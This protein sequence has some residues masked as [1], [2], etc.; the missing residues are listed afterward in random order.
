[1]GSLTFA[2]SLSFLSQKALD[3]R[4]KQ[5]IA[6]D[7]SDLPVVTSYITQVMNASSAVKLHNVS[8]WFNQ[9][10]VITLDSST[11]TAMA[12]LPMVQNVKL[13][14]RYPNGVYKTQPTSAPNKFASVEPLQAKD[15][16]QLITD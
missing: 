2:D 6:L 12:A 1:M 13:V 4:N 8:K 16:A 11:V 3:R 9:I 15:P 7:S 10:V 14:A 5:G